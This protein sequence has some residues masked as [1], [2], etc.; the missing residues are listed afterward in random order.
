MNTTAIYLRVSSAVQTV[1]NQ[2]PDIERAI[3]A[4][5]LT[6]T[7]V[8]E[9]QASAAKFRPEFE[10]M[11]ADAR[12]KKFTTLVIWALDRFGR[13][14]AGNVRD[15]LELDKAGIKV[16]SVKEPWMD[17]EGPV[18]DL[19]VAIFGWVAQH[20]RSRLIERTKA[21]LMIAKAN[22]KVLG[23]PSTVLKPDHAEI[24]AAWKAE[25]EDTRGGYRVLAEKLGGV[26]PMT[27]RKLA[28]GVK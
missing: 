21:G 12:E 26:S 27:A 9:E 15:V 2:R 13:S 8:Y 25:P 23:H 5:G 16:V 24:I 22:G 19:L 3:A 18:R 28:M 10:R 1:E 7:H 6:V 11:M 14:M 17:T 4:R 20:E